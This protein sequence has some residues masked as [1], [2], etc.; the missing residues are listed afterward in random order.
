MNPF[1][2]LVPRAIRS[3]KSGEVAESGQQKKVQV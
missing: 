2:D 1:D 3:K